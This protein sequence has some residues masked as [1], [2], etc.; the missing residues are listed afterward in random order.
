M[1]W[2]KRHM[3]V[4]RQHKGSPPWLPPE[5]RS[6]DRRHV[7]HDMATKGGCWELPL[8]WQKTCICLWSHNYHV[9]IEGSYQ[10][11]PLPCNWCNICMCLWTNDMVAELCQTKLRGV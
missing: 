6:W 11:L 4:L 3:Q 7:T 10:E 2:V 1:S 5:T 9:V 8:P